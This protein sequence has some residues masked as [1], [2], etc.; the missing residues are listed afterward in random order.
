M[1]IK[2]QRDI[3]QEVLSLISSVARTT[4]K[5][6][7]DKA[8]SEFIVLHAQDDTASFR[9]FNGHEVLEIDLEAEVLEHGDTFLPLSKF[10]TTCQNSSSEILTISSYLTDSGGAG[11]RISGTNLV[12][13][14]PVRHIETLP[15]AW[16]APPLEIPLEVAAL[17]ALLQRV[18]K[19]LV[20]GGAG[21]FQSIRLIFRPGQVWAVAA[22]NHKI[23]GASHKNEAIINKADALIPVIFLDSFEKVLS[24]VEETIYLG[25][26]ENKLSIGTTQ[27]I[28]YSCPAAIEGPPNVSALFKNNGMSFIEVDSG[29]LLS[30][31]KLT[32][33][34]TKSDDSHGYIAVSFLRDGIKIAGTEDGSVVTKI[35][36]EGGAGS[37][38]LTQGFKSD[39]FAAGV[40]KSKKVRIWYGAEEMSRVIFEHVDDLFDCRFVVSPA[41]I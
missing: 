1:Q 41:R 16:S 39:Y 18:R 19:A 7:Q 35:D 37:N 4:S 26:S 6:A 2:I 29:E 15:P 9:I 5:N 25:I 33:A 22:S 28:R 38:E 24:N 12:A 30:A 10:I 13:R 36:S 23:A 8:A 40:G 32:S 27:G 11:V 3:L 17:R 21:M 20:D 34:G 31:L 14:W